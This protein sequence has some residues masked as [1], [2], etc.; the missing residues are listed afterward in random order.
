MPVETDD[1]VP[2]VPRTGPVHV[3][4]EGGRV[5]TY[6]ASARLD[7]MDP[8]RK[9]AWKVDDVKLT[10]FNELSHPTRSIAGNLILQVERLGPGFRVTVDERVEPD[11]GETAMTRGG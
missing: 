3:V 4:H 7:M 2:F 6:G 8:S 10:L 5:V 9:D 1:L 11:P